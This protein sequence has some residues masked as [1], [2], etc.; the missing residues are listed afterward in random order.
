M[1]YISAVAFPS[2][3]LWVFGIPLA[4]LGILIRNKRILNLMNKKE[5][6]VAENEEILQMKVKY[7]FL[8]AGFKPTTFFWEVLIMYRKIFIIMSSVVLSTVS[9]E[10]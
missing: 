2:I 4:A 10:S 6:T 5:I 9:S 7:G 1:F 8:F 3:A